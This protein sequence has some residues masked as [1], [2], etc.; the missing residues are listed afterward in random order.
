[1]YTYEII[2]KR[3]YEFVSGDLDGFYIGKFLVYMYEIF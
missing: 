1:M 2:L 3:D